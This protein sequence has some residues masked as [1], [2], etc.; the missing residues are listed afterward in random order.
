MDIFGGQNRWTNNLDLME[1]LWWNADDP[2]SVGLVCCERKQK[3]KIYKLDSYEKQKNVCVRA[4]NWQ[5]Q[6]I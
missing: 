2:W 5:F 3:L 6:K 4:L 1:T